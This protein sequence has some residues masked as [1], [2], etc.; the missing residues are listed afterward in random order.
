MIATDPLLS[1]LDEVARPH[2]GRWRYHVL[3]WRIRRRL[4][5]EARVR[6]KSLLGI[7]RNRRWHQRQWESRRAA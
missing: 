1:L 3:R 4:A 5:Y 6:R 7:A 2:L